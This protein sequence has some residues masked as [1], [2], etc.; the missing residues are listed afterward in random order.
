MSDIPENSVKS[1]EQDIL[2]KLVI[3]ENQA[4]ADLEELV[5]LAEG[6]LGIEKTTGQIIILNR[7]I[8]G[9]REQCMLYLIG[10]TIAKKLGLREVAEMTPQELSALV[11]KPATTL[12]KPLGQL[13]N[14]GFV[15]RNEGKYLCAFYRGKEYLQTL[16]K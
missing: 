9:L 5:R 3:D 6:M 11:R 10:A 14:D 12:S 15:T 13:V 2:S 7:S 1:R 8:L 4:S 16:R